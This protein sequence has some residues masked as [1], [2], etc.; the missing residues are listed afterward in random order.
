MEMKTYFNYII[1]QDEDILS[2]LSN[3]SSL[4]SQRSERSRHSMSSTELR[5][6]H[7]NSCLPP[8][9]SLQDRKIVSSKRRRSSNRTTLSEF[10]STGSGKNYC[11]KL[12]ESDYDNKSTTSCSTFSSSGSA[13][14][15]YS[16]RRS[17]KR[18][19]Q[20]S[21]D[22][23]EESVISAFSSLVEI[24]IEK[25]APQSKYAKD[26]VERVPR[27]CSLPSMCFA[28]CEEIWD[29]MCKMDL[30]YQRD[31]NFFKNQAYLGPQMRS[32]LLDWIMDVCESYKMHRETLY[33]AIDYVDRYLAIQKDV[34]KAHLQLIGMNSFESFS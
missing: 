12:E 6:I 23:D 33:L 27:S 19:L 15:S 29:L 16:S 4:H 25:V 32:I 8:S 26:V 17:S 21:D 5:E 3:V 1:K 30:K 14:S 2:R 20:Q 22:D 28:N 31:P 10:S 11:R 13:S 34:P 18:R 9:T 7:Y 24:G